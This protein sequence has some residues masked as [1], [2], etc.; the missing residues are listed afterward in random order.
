[1][2]G[3]GFALRRD[4]TT[5]TI[6]AAIDAARRLDGKARRN[7]RTALAKEV[8]RAVLEARDAKRVKG[9]AEAIRTLTGAS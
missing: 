5:A 3:A 8:D 1:M 6:V 9:M 7:A 2:S 4:R